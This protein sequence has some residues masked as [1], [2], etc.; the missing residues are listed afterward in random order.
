MEKIVIEV[1]VEH[2]GEVQFE[3]EA[4]GHKIL[5]D[6]PSQEGGYDEGMTPPE[7]LLA[8]LGTCAAYYAVEYLRAHN[9]ANGSTH[10]RVGADKVKGPP[11]LD[12]FRIEV[13]VHSDLS[14][15]HQAGVERAVHKCL[16]HNTL[17][18]PPKIELHVKAIS[19][20]GN[21]T[22]S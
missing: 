10:V 11:R 6:Q 19:P 1:T 2:L 20:T 7:L 5:C 18:N 21:G 9:L 3:V 16:I 13:D 22:S 17:L 15:A 12:N 14:A 4:R 8:S